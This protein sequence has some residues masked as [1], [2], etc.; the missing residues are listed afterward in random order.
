[1]R[2]NRLSSSKRIFEYN[3]G[4]YNGTLRNIGFNQDLE[5]FDLNETNTYKDCNNNNNNHTGNNN[6][7]NKNRHRKIW[8]NPPFCKLSNFNIGKYFLNSIEKHFQKK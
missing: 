8:F 1:M 4:L 3:K 2:I 5:F 7:K 6:C